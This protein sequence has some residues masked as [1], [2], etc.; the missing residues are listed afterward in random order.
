MW[1][2]CVKKYTELPIVALEFIGGIVNLQCFGD[3]LRGK[4][5]CLALDA[6]V[7]PMVMAGKGSSPMT[8]LLH[9]KMIEDPAYPLVA[10]S[11]TVSHEHGTYNPVADA[12]SQVL[13]ITLTCTVNVIN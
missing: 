9:A 3:R 2:I 11:L 4:K 13:V 7:C 8:R 1:H 10:E 6:L 5:A 12:F